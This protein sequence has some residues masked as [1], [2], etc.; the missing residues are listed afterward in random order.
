[1]VESRCSKDLLINP[2]TG[3]N[4]FIGNLSCVVMEFK[5]VIKINT[6]VSVH[7][8]DVNKYS[9]E[10]VRTVVMHCGKVM[11]HCVTL[12]VAAIE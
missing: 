11:S 10:R 1:M 4:C 7:C 2:S 8:S 3:F 5:L 12:A 9:I 6:K